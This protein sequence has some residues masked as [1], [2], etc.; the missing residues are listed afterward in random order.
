MNKVPSR[1]EHLERSYYSLGY[2]ACEA[3][4]LSD[5]VFCRFRTEEFEFSSDQLL[6]WELSSGDKNHNPGGYLQ[7]KVS[8]LRALKKKL[9]RNH[10]RFRPD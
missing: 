4:I 9:G 7:I 1:A 5:T 6:G 3:R 8:K 10:G 2:A